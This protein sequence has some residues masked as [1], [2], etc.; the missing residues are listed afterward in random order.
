MRALPAVVLV[1]LVLAGGVSHSAW[2]TAVALAV[3][4]GAAGAVLAVIRPAAPDPFEYRSRVARGLARLAA[5]AV[6]VVMVGGFVLVA[7]VQ[8]RPDAYVDGV[9]AGLLWI[10]LP[11]VVVLTIVTHARRARR[12]ARSTAPA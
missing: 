10:G 8:G 2:P 6:A 1:G 9:L 7:V 11:G 3:A 5:G 12:E 4:F